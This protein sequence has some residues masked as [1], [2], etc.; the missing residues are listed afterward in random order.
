MNKMKIAVY[1]PGRI[2]YRHTE[3]VTDG[4]SDPLSI[5]INDK[6]A[7]VVVQPGTSAKV[8]YSISHPDAIDSEA[9]I[10]VDWP[11]GDVTVLTAASIEG[12]VTAL[13]LVSTGASTWEVSK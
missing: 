8:Q 7:I 2:S 1:S 3:T 13:R 6:P 5:E 4:T 9:G 12:A 10:W 11:E